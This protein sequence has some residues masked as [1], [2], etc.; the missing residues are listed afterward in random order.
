MARLLPGAELVE[1]ADGGHVTLM[2]HPDLVNAHFTAFVRR[3]AAA[4]RSGHPSARTRLGQAERGAEAAAERAEK[5]AGSGP[6]ARRSMRRVL[7]RR[8]A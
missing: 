1:V 5:A 2:E 8:G 4:A 3:A 7:R 6:E